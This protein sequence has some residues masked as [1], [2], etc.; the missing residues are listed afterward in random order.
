MGYYQVEYRKVSFAFPL[1]LKRSPQQRSHFET[2]PVHRSA[3]HVFHESKES[4]GFV[5]FEH[6][7][8]KQHINRQTQKAPGLLA[9]VNTG[10]LHL[11]LGR[12][13]NS[14][15]FFPPQLTHRGL[16]PATMSGIFLRLPWISCNMWNRP[17][18]TKEDKTH[19]GDCSARLTF[20]SFA[21]LRGIDQLP[22]RRSV[23]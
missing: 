23:M 10:A 6:G 16:T 5:S 19:A 2:G 18:Y 8:D 3:I 21:P 4:K 15:L 20:R 13:P 12:K 22:R 17:S 9:Q 7:H 1:L 14:V 11:M